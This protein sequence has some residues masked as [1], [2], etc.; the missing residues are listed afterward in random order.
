[1]VFLELFTGSVHCIPVENDKPSEQKVSR[2]FVHSV[3]R[4]FVPVAFA[5]LFDRSTFQC[6]TI[7]GRTDTRP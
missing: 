4:W 1:M 7:S 5:E 3:F 2:W 6:L